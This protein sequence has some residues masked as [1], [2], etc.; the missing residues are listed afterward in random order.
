MTEQQAI[1]KMWENVKLRGL[2]ASTLK[3]YTRCVRDF[4]AFCERLVGELDETGVRKFLSHLI[5][6]RRLAPRSVNQFSSA[7]RFFFAVG[8]NRHM[9]YNQIP[10]LKLPKK[11]PDILTRGEIA[12]MLSACFTQNTEHSSCWFMVPDSEPG[13]FSGCA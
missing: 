6:E 12:T 11:L 13:K 9:N 3:N 8:L 2:S 4:I 1:E 7:I 5:D 10:M